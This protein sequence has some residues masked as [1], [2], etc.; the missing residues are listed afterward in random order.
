MTFRRLRLAVA[1]P[2][3]RWFAMRSSG[4]LQLEHALALATD[5]NR[6]KLPGK[7]RVPRNRRKPLDDT[8][9]GMYSF[10][11]MTNETR[12]ELFLGL[13]ATQLSISRLAAAIESDRGWFAFPLEAA[14]RAKIETRI[15]SMQEERAAFLEATAAYNRAKSWLESS[16]VDER[17]G[18]ATDTAQNQIALSLK[19][20]RACVRRADAIADAR[21][22][23][24]ETVSAF[25]LAA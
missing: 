17:A 11:T 9:R 6:R 5:R 22:C 24:R 20:A 2:S 15:A 1:F 18:R 25:R 16:F 8:F 4:L 23:E 21:T 3:T 14:Q 19:E 10:R 7:S 12:N 13:A